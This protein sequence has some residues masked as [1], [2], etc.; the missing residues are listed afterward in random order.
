MS[1]FLELAARYRCVLFDAYGVLKEH[2]GLYPG[3]PDRLRE[4]SQD[5]AEVSAEVLCIVFAERQLVRGADEV[6]RQDVGVLRLDDRA[7]R[8][9]PRRRR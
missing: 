7:V 8:G 5:A 6:L 2:A 9:L 1:A 4:E 3:V